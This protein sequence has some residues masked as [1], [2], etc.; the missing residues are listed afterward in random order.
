MRVAIGR[1]DLEHTVTDLKN[2]DIE[3]AAAQ[4]VHRDFLIFLFIETVSQ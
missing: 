2:R 1:L 3:G 4:V